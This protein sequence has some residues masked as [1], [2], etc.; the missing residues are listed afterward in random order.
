MTE[1]QNP[2][3]L[4]GLTAMERALLIR[5]DALEQALMQDLQGQNKRIATLEAEL[6]ARD[7][8]IERLTDTLTSLLGP[9]APARS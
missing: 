1:A 2:P 5:I 4:S 3:P 6:Q 7:A 9:V 8:A